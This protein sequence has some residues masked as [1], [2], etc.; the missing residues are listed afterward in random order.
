[1]D[2]GKGRGGVAGLAAARALFF[3]RRLMVRWAGGCGGN[4]RRESGRQAGAAGNVF[5][6]LCAQRG[7][8]GSRMPSSQTGLVGRSGAKK[9]ARKSPAVW[10]SSLNGM[11]SSSP[12]SNQPSL[13]PFIVSGGAGDKWKQQ[14][15]GPGKG[16]HLILNGSNDPVGKID[17]SPD[18][19][20]LSLQDIHQGLQG[21]HLR[22]PSPIVPNAPFTLSCDNCRNCSRAAPL[23]RLQPPSWH[24]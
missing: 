15:T 9:K 16:N 2:G 5:M 14:K 22:P 24:C 19:G 17:T 12:K 23:G 4:C 10:C 20:R 21:S 11:H 6:L 13:S 3:S 1:M 7:R 18:S 8:R